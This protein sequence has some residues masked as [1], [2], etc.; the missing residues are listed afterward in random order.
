MAIQ[1]SVTA[2]LTIAEL[3][4]TRAELLAKLDEINHEINQ[5]AGE[6]LV[7]VPAKE[8]RGKK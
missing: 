5:R 3:A 4:D 8:T 6:P 1:Q 2:R 7:Y